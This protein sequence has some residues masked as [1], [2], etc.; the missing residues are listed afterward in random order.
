MTENYRNIAKSSIIISS[1]KRLDKIQVYGRNAII[2]SKLTY[3]EHNT[4]HYKLKVK[5]VA[6]RNT[7]VYTCIII[8]T[9][10]FFKVYSHKI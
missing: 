3:K 9:R 4:T 6:Y 7:N 10:Y 5:Y 2:V 1:T 8:N